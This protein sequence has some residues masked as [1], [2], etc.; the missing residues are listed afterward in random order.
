MASSPLHLLHPKYV[1][2]LA[3]SRSV[4]LWRFASL[5][6]AGGSL[7][8]ICF[9]SP[10][11][12]CKQSTTWTACSQSLVKRNKSLKEIHQRK[13]KKQISTEQQSETKPTSGHTS[14]VADAAG[15]KP[16]A[17]LF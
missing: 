17:M 11:F 12:G 7:S 13:L 1:H 16:W 4:V 9:F 8:R 14:D 5:V 6:C 15:T 2:L 3:W 10:N